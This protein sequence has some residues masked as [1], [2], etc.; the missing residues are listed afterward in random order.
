MVNELCPKKLLHFKLEGDLDLKAKETSPKTW[1][2]LV[3]Y[4]KK[5]YGRVSVTKPPY[6]NMWGTNRIRLSDGLPSGLHITG[7][8]LDYLFR[9]TVMSAMTPAIAGQIML[10]Y[11]AKVVQLH[12]LSCK[13]KSGDL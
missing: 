9:S 8:L 12:W 5:V 7:L 6:C 1:P 4:Y 13:I 11:F 2:K 3:F 10:V